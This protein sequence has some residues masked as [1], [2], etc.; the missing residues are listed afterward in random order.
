M[1]F[2]FC[3]MKNI[4]L[5]IFFL[6]LSLAVSAQSFPSWLAGVWEIP[7]VS[8]YSGSSYEAW[9]KVTDTHLEAMTYRMF[10][11]DTV[12]F[13][14][15][16]LIYENGNVLLRMSAE[17][18]GKRFMA[19]FKGTMMREDLWAFEC[20]EADYPSAVYYRLLSEDQVSV[21]SEVSNGVDVCSDFIMYRRK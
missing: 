15:K 9:I 2:Y 17:K 6:T 16:T 3:D 12:Y 20:P 14:Q 21:W 8:V 5:A 4:L 18:E 11:N 19:N 7:S 13:D 1:L 10:G